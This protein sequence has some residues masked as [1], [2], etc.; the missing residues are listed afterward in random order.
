MLPLPKYRKNILKFH[1]AVFLLCAIA[2]RNIFL[3]FR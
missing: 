1:I 3:L 2:N